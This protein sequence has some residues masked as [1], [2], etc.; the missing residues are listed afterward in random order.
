MD[1]EEEREAVFWRLEG[2]GYRV[3]QGLVE[4]YVLLGFLYTSL[5]ERRSGRF[6]GDWKG[7][8]D[9]GDVSGG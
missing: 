2:I 1:E 7:W 8:E 6:A 9:E 5:W 4:R 3:G